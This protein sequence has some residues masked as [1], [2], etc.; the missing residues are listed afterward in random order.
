MKK[1]ILAALCFVGIV[2]QAYAG[3]S[4]KESLVLMPIN[5]VNLLVSD[6][7]DRENIKADNTVDVAVDDSFENFKKKQQEEFDAFKR[8]G[9]S[10]Q[11]IAARKRADAKALA[12]RTESEEKRLQTSLQWALRDGLQNRFQVFSG[13]AHSDAKLVATG[14][15]TKRTYGYFLEVSIQNTTTNKVVYA[16]SSPC[17]ACNEIQVG[18]KF[19][20][21]GNV[22]A[23][24]PALASV[25]PAPQP[26]PT[27]VDDA[28]NCYADEFVQVCVMK[29]VV[30]KNQTPML[31]F[32][33]KNLTQD[34]M[35]LGAN[36]NGF[37]ITNIANDWMNSTTT[38]DEG[39]ICNNRMV[40]LEFI[41]TYFHNTTTENSYNR[42]PVGKSINIHTSWNCTN[43]VTGST[44][45]VRLYLVRLTDGK[46]VPF[47]ATLQDIPWKKSP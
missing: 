30:S 42:I 19:R 45:D 35:F 8:G 4:D 32:V 31:T 3:D 9:P 13:G 25:A 16:N 2:S 38:D 44:L 33:A 23:P 27:T 7:L 26:S 39:N 14:S 43:K 37:N 36:D 18:I 12:D 20:D 1:I 29:S 5:G 17:H 47:V 22:P 10:P 11:A 34:A 41:K 24:V 21:L 46:M 28:G 6:I 40:G 15:V